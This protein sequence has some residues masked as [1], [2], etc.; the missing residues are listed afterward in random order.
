MTDIVWELVFA[1]GDSKL[2]TAS[3]ADAATATPHFTPDVL[4]GYTLRVTGNKDGVASSV[5]V[6]IEA[7]DAPVFWRRVSYK[8]T[9]PS[10]ALNASTFVGGVY[11]AAAVK[12]VACAQQ[13]HE[14]AD[15]EEPT[16]FISFALATARAGGSA[17]DVWEARLGQLLGSRMPT[18]T[19]AGS[20]PS[21]TMMV[22]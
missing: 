21:P 20:A 11:G 19:S 18:W 15:G 7:I 1:P 10:A 22:T 14:L 5:F 4:G 3:I 17:G 6:H 9:A 12:E 2:T 16:S 8:P 13:S